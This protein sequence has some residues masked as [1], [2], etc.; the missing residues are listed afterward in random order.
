MLTVSL[1]IS[2]EI[3]G[4]FT[5][6]CLYTLPNLQ[7]NHFMHGFLGRRLGWI[8]DLDSFNPKPETCNIVI[9]REFQ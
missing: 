1:E 7:S 2:T 5:L 3:N 9:S 8:K 6:H 4:H